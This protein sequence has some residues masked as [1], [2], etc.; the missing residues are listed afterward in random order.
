MSGKDVVAACAG[1]A[2]TV[3]NFVAEGYLN[4]L[5][6]ALVATLTIMVLIQ[7]YRINRRELRRSHQDD[8]SSG[9]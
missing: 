9:S 1:F 2:A 3:W 5:L 8:P 4:T 7:R 6:A